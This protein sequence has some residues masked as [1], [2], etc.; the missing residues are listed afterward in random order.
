MAQINAYLFFEDNCREAMNFYK[1]C[2]GGEL[3]IQAIEETPV[4]NQFPPEAQK[5]IMHAMLVGDGWGLMASDMMDP[6]FVRGNSISLALI[7]TSSE[8]IKT[9]FS[10]LSAGGQVTH[11][12]KEEFWGSTFGQLTDKFGVEWMLNYDKK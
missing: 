9:F 4:A 12:L 2:L 7:C 8:E 10:K 5:K 11:P 6:G 1:E 3:S